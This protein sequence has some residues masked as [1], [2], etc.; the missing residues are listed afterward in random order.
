MTT[1]AKAPDVKI[2]KGQEA[3]DLVLDYVKRMNRP[4]GAVDVCANLKGA[5]PKTQ[6]QKILL[7]LTEKEELV[8]KTYGKT[9]FFVAN[10]AKIASV[11]AEQ[12]TALE[13]ELKVIEDANKLAAAGLR[14]VSNELAKIKGTPTDTELDAQI[15]EVACTT[16]ERVKRLAP[17]RAGTTLISAEAVA[18]IDSDWVRWRAEWVRRK[19]IFIQFWQLVTDTLPP[20]DATMLAEDLGIEYDTAEHTA[21]ERSSLCAVQSNSLKRKR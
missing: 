8:M 4:F 12:L 5:V 17:L 2:L 16:E 15:K 13:T 14:T 18:Q 1:K 20:Q 6:T 19:K 7:A 3:E 10:Q 11:P 9:T 21:L